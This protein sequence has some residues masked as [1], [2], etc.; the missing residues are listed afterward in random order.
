MWVVNIVPVIKKNGQVRVY[1][2]FRDL[3]KVCPKDDFPLPHIDV[4]IDNTTGYQMLSFMDGFSRYNQICL[5]EEEQE[6]TSFT[7]P[8][9]IYCYVSMPFDLKNA[10]ATYQRAM[11]T[12]FH[13]MMNVYMEVYVDDILVKSRTRKDHPEILAK[14]LQRAREHQLKMNPKKCVFGVSSGKLLRF[15]ISQRGIEIDPNKAKAIIEM[16]PPKNLKQ[17]RRLIGRL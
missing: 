5:V 6:K 17:L 1:I 14:V 12:I 10:G 8:W 3:N 16:A 15:I 13:D 2:D 4:L 9:G 11:T 7:T